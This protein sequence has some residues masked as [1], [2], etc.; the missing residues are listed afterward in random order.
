M[1][2]VKKW[3][4]NSGK[5]DYYQIFYHCFSARFLRLPNKSE[6]LKLTDFVE[7]SRTNVLDF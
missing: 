4:E 1:T 5:M 7:F 2:D 3:L 6:N